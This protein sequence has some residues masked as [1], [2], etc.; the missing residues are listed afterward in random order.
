MSVI[1]IT[2]EFKS[3][4]GIRDHLSRSLLIFGCDRFVLRIC[5]VLA[6]DPFATATSLGNS[7][8]VQVVFTEVIPELQV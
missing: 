5:N 4:T 6:L 8:E 7:W 1:D 2:P 3:D